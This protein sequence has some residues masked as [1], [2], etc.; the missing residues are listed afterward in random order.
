MPPTGGTQHFSSCVTQVVIRT[1]FYVFCFGGIIKG[2][3]TTMG[4]K[5]FLGGKQLS[6]APRTVVGAST[7]LF[8][9]KVYFSIGSFRP[10]FS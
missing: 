10:R 5:F 4:I 3:P 7:L 9:F 8:K 2:R 1:R 6:I